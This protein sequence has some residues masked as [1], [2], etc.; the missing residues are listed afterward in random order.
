MYSNSEEQRKVETE[1]LEGFLR[2]YESYKTFIAEATEEKKQTPRYQH[3]KKIV[4]GVE[5]FY[6]TLTDDMKKIF[7]MRYGSEHEEYDFG[8]IADEIYTTTVRAKRLRDII[9]NKFATEIGW[10]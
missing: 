8:D 6:P 1:V 10:V 2:D 4:E 3:R 9:I 5:N 7:D